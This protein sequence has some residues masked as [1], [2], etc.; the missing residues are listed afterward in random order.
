MH[1][2][3]YFAWKIKAAP[4]QQEYKKLYTYES[5]DGDQRLSG[6]S[7]NRSINDKKASS[8][9]PITEAN[10]K[11]LAELIGEINDSMPQKI[12]ELLPRRNLSQSLSPRSLK[13]DSIIHTQFTPLINF[14]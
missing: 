9:S 6:I 7:S 2:T 11:L 1:H 8:T 12:K 5:T 3:N 14:L 13:T 4:A 10:S